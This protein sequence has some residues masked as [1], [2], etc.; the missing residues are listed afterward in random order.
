MYP[1]PDTQIFDRQ[2]I[3]SFSNYGGGGG[4][5]GNLVSRSNPVTVTKMLAVEG[6]GMRLWWAP[7]CPSFDLFLY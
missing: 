2:R 3:T 6:L 7:E 4:G 1:S 5:R